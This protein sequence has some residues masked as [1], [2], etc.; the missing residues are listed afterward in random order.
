MSL[1]SAGESS[2]M[3]ILVKTDE[4]LFFGIHIGI[5]I[6]QPSC[7]GWAGIQKRWQVFYYQCVGKGDG[8]H[9]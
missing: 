4:P 6:A 2:T 5:A 7:G 1:T 9:Y 8:L 3:R